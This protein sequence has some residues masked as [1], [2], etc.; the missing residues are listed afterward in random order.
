MREGSTK[1]SSISLR[2][3]VSG[4]DASFRATIGNG[5]LVVVIISHVRHT[6]TLANLINTPG[7]FTIA[8]NK[9]AF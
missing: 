1:P 4:K 8:R 7:R 6:H 3:A 2:S 5:S 9:N